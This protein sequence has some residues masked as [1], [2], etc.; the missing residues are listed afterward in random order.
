MFLW[1]GLVSPLAAAYA[2]WH[3]NWLLGFEIVL[4]AHNIL[5]F[6]VLVPSSRSF[7][8]LLSA[9][10][11]AICSWIRS[12]QWY[13]WETK[14]NKKRPDMYSALCNWISSIRWGWHRNEYC[15]EIG[16]FVPKLVSLAHVT[17]FF[18]VGSASFDGLVRNKRKYRAPSHFYA[19]FCSWIRSTRGRWHWNEYCAARCRD[20]VVADGWD[21]DTTS[22]R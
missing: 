4:F 16:R 6:T 15:A 11:G 12:I 2:T 8:A 17:L 9:V 18:V 19:F 3:R 13:K 10:L 20:C 5:Y 22:W 14:D 7:S 1:H 21:E